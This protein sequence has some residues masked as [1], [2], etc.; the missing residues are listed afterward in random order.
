MSERRPVP[1]LLP[2]CRERL[3]REPKTCKRR[4]REVSVEVALVRLY[5]LGKREI[6][7]LAYHPDCAPKRCKYLRPLSELLL[8]QPED[9]V[10]NGNDSPSGTR[11]Q[12]RC[13][14]VDQ[15]LAIRGVR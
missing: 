15:R 4:G 9:E 12:R 1:F 5:L 3:W 10:R 14:S 7:M 2:E 6:G 13:Q 8:A 11:N